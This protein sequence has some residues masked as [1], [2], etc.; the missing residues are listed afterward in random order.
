VSLF[1]SLCVCSPISLSL[2]VFRSFM[3]L[4]ILMCC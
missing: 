4:R 2:P 1:L 3:T